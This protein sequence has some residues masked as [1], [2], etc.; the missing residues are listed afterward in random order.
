LIIVDLPAPFGPSSP[1]KEPR[2]ID[3]LT[4]SSASFSG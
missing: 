1:K 3:R 4:L 2:G